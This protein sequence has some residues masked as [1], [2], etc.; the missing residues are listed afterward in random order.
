MCR[1][2]RT[3]RARAGAGATEWYPGRGTFIVVEVV[4]LRSGPSTVAALLPLGDGLGPAFGDEH[5]RLAQRKR[6]AIADVPLREIDPVDEVRVFT[7][8]ADRSHLE[9]TRL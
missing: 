5:A 3:A 6:K 9:R 8:Q 7:E 1:V 4:M 2:V